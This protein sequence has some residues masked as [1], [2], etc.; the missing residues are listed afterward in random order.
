M[1]NSMAGIDPEDIEHRFSR[2][3]TV[4]DS[5]GEAV[6]NRLKS[7][8]HEINKLV[9]S[10]SPALRS[11]IQRLEQAAHVATTAPALFDP[12][13]PDPTQAAP[14][15]APDAVA[16]TSAITV[17]PTVTSEASSEPSSTDSATESKG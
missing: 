3:A 5:A 10:D 4:A 15:P 8:A 9:G 2:L 1:E 13:Q 6:V 12:P 16:S 7:F 14:V 17:T 11:I